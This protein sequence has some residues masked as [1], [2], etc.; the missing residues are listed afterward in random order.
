MNAPEPLPFKPDWPDP[1]P[2]YLREERPPPPP[3]PLEAVFSE[4]W[5]AWV[6][7]AAQSKGAPPDYVMAGVLAVCAS[8]IG[9]TRWAAPWEGWAEPPIL[10]AMVVGQPSTN[11]SPG[12]DAALE[13]LRVLERE[14]HAEAEPS[15]T[16]WSEKAELAKLAESVWRE[17]TRAALKAG[18][19][20]P[21]KPSAADPGP[22]PFAPRLCVAD[23]TVEKLAV[24]LARQPRGLL[25]SRDELT[26]WLQNMERYSS[27]SDRPFWLECYGGRGYSVER[28][29]RES[30]HVERLSSSVLGG[31]QPDRLASLL[32]KA[33]DDGLLARFLPIWPDPA[34]VIRPQ[35]V[36]DDG[37][38]L[39]ALRRLWSLKMVEEGEGGMRPFLLPFSEEAR[40]VMDSLRLEVREMERGAAGL[41][42]SFLGKGP[43]LAARLA[44]ALTLMDWASGEA[45]EEPRRIEARP[46]ERAAFFLRAYL[47][48]MA[49]RTYGAASAS[50]KERAGRKLLALLRKEKLRGFST[51]EILRLN[52][53]DLGSSERLEP[54][55]SALEE[56]E[57]IRPAPE[58]KPRAKGRPER[59]YL[60]N[61]AIFDPPHG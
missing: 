57:V 32:L 41:T 10:W 18:E 46:M 33:D 28:M 47:W 4:R 6:R 48:P 53:A 26:G 14:L 15:L 56:G 24:L 1:D 2:R 8:L 22:E 19:A 44:L 49:W 42:L 54:A 43:G 52:R 61:P 17:A 7:T 16:A 38:M 31:V 45:E 27:A 34:P 13:P 29:G 25:Q 40:K 36:Q 37:F 3:A 5:A 59:R 20:P 60:V 11:K 21:P 55:L 23:A 50:P 30:I 9:N 58:A 12:L 51:R 35:S 39:R